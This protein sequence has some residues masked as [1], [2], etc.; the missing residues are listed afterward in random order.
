M[1]LKKELEA[2]NLDCEVICSTSA[3]KYAGESDLIITTTSAHGQKIIDIDRSA[4]MCYL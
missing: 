2:I 3:N 4:W 1:D